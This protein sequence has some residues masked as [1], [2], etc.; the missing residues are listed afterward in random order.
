[1]TCGRCGKHKH[2]KKAPSFMA[3]VRREMGAGFGKLSAEQKQ[4]LRDI[5]AIKKVG[6]RV[7]SNPVA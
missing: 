4:V 6:G 7:G 2:V 3:A 5:D 1:M